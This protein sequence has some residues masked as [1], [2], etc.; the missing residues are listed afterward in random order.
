M[1]RIQMSV[2]S[3]NPLPGGV[4]F[5]YPLKTLENRRFS[6]VFRGY[7]KGIPGS[8]GL[9]TRSRECAFMHFDIS[10]TECLMSQCSTV[11]Q[12]LGAKPDLLRWVDQS[13]F[14]CKVPNSLNNNL[15]RLQTSHNQ[16][17]NYN[18]VIR[19]G[20]VSYDYDY[21]ETRS[22]YQFCCSL[23]QTSSFYF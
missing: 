2:F 13:L 16:H 5:L 19:N 1:I 17:V 3:F 10:K 22:Y 4:P 18:I 14:H 15:G 11:K 20:S 12:L 6:D 8:Y 9:A 23:N 7:K 21:K